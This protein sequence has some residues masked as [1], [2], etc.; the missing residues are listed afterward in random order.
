[1]LLIWKGW[2]IVV[3][4]IALLAA[5]LAIVIAEWMGASTQGS[6][7]M[8]AGSLI[9]AGI[10]TWY[11]G[12]RMNRDMDR[13]LVDPATSQEV[14]V[15]NDHSLFFVRVEWWGPILVV[16]GVIGVLIFLTGPAR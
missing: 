1:M 13:K 5:T 2:G 9:P 8:M 12:K 15:R 10:A 16:L 6:D 3:A 14:V 4:G 11:V 7:V